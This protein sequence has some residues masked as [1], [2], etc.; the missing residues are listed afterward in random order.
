MLEQHGFLAT[1]ALKPT[2]DVVCVGVASHEF[3]RDLLATTADEQGHV[4]LDR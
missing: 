4:L 2:T 3:E 1:H